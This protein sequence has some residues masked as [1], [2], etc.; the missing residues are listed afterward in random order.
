M[1][2][3][4]ANC[5]HS[6]QRYWRS[7]TAKSNNKISFGSHI[8]CSYTPSSQLLAK[9]YTNLDFLLHFTEYWYISVSFR[10]CM[11]VLHKYSDNTAEPSFNMCCE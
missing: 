4:T 6:Y 7:K 2:L 11:Y 8:V 1:L 5:F 9:V 10:S 3:Q